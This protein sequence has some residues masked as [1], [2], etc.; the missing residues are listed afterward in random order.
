MRRRC[1][2]RCRRRRRPVVVVAVVV[3]ICLF[4][5]TKSPAVAQAFLGAH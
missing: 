2:R 4:S 3:C 5:G 1:G